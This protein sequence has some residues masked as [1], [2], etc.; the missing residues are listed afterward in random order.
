MMND[1]MALQA[2]EIQRRAKAEAA[3]Q[4]SL[5]S[6]QSEIA[7]LRTEAGVTP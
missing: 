3:Y 1:Q 6:N 2:V 4:R 7:K 5:A